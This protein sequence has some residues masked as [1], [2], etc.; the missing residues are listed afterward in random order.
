MIC[1]KKKKDERVLSSFLSLANNIAYLC[2]NTGATIYLDD[3]RTASKLSRTAKRIGA[4]NILRRD[5]YHACNNCLWSA[6]CV[7]QLG[8]IPRAGVNCASLWPNL[9]TGPLIIATNTHLALGFGYPFQGF[10]ALTRK[11]T[12]IHPFVQM[13]VRKP[14]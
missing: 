14:V 4:G 8:A 9:S 2:L 7:F 12:R 13:S 3:P 6:L 1:R 5:R 11:S 10:S